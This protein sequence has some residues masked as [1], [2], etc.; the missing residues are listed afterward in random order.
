MIL[1]VETSTEA[2]SVAVREGEAAASLDMTHQKTRSQHIVSAVRYLLGSLD[3]DIGRVRAACAGVGPGSFTGIRMGL[4]FVNSLR[5]LYGIPLAG[6]SS[7]DMLA[8]QQQQWYTTVIPFVRSRKGEVYT[9]LYRNGARAT[10]YLVLGKREFAAFLQEQRPDCLTG[11]ARTAAELLNGPPRE[12]G[13]LPAGAAFVEAAPRAAS[14]V[15]LLQEPE[16]SGLFPRDAY[17]TPL[18]LRG[19]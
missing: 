12:G 6:I 16:S 7:L 4:T 9:A 13:S 11:S 14:M 1:A 18:Y 2:F 19:I 8:R 15:R 5:Q 10:G 17:L 3:L